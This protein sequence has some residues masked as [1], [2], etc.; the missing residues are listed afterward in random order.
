MKLCMCTNML[1]YEYELIKKK[2]GKPLQVV[3]DDKTEKKDFMLHCRR[4]LVPS[5]SFPPEDNP[6]LCPVCPCPIPSCNHHTV[7]EPQCLC[8]SHPFFTEHSPKSLMTEGQRQAV[9]P[10]Q[11]VKG[12]VHL[13][14][15]TLQTSSSAGTL[16]THSPVPI[17]ERA[18]QIH[19][20]PTTGASAPSEP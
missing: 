20:V 6:L 10:F 5:H 14:C 16:C 11:V 18:L 9:K 17:Y 12:S 2:K 1:L 3:N 19:F 4:S 13:W 8:S 15:Q 7:T